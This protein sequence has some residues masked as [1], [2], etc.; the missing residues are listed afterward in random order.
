ML[1]RKE[2]KQKKKKQKILE[3]SFAIEHYRYELDGYFSF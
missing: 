3:K 2:T 1:I